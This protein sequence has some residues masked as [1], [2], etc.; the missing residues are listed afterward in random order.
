MSISIKA[1]LRLLNIFVDYSLLQSGHDCRSDSVFIGH[2][3]SIRG[4]ADLCRKQQG[5]QYFMLDKQDDDDESNCFWKD[6]VDSSCIEG[7]NQDTHK[8]TYALKG[9]QQPF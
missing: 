4:C 1:Q 8:N 2:A 9:I 5:C 3:S 7:W 6:M